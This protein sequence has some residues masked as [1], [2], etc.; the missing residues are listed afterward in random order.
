MTT[1][2]QCDFTFCRFNRDK[3]C[4]NELNRNQC[5]SLVKQILGD[6]YKKFCEW[7]KENG[8]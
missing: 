7:E 8:N 2:G 3:K 5:M 1:F 6:R 4:I